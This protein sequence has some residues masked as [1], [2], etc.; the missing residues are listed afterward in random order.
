MREGVRL[1][2][3]MFR[4][5]KDLAVLE[6]VTELLKKVPGAAALNESKRLIQVPLREQVKLRINIPTL[7]PDALPILTVTHP[8]PHAW[9][10]SNGVVWS[11]SFQTINYKYDS[12]ALARLVSMTV[13]ALATASPSE[14]RKGDSGYYP[15]VVH[16]ADSSM[17]SHSGRGADRADMTG[18]AGIPTEAVA[19]L[20]VSSTMKSD[21]EKLSCEEL[22]SMLADKDAYASFVASVHNMDSVESTMKE[23]SEKN[24]ALAQANMDKQQQIAELK[25]QIAIIRST[26]VQE[27]RDKYERLAKEHN[28]I[29]V[30]I[31][32]KTLKEKMVSAAA[33][34]DELSESL[35]QDLLSKKLATDVFVEM[36]SA[37]REIFHKRSIVLQTLH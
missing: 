31:N 20:E 18:E 4:G 28:N 34:S 9:I 8:I 11:E 24:L 3:K 10:K 7:Y 30:N 27:I 23:V 37:Q 14:P 16:T 26:E 17:G 21:L 33:E 29:L 22:Y 25:N 2:H 15:P 13:N 36:Y 19:K 6:Q 1:L 5:T 12:L 32:M 35:H